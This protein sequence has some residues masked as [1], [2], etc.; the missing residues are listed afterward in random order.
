MQMILKSMGVKVDKDDME[1]YARE[2]DESESGKF[3]FICS[4]SSSIMNRAAIWQNWVKVNFPDS[5]SSTS[6]AYPS[7]SSLS[8]F[9]PMLFRII[10]MVV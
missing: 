10:C 8:T 3:T 1:G 2:V 5:D 6:L 9:T 4:S 7:M